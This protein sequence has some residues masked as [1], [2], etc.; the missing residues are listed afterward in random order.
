M[1]SVKIAALIEGVE[2]KEAKGDM[3]TEVNGLALDSRSIQRGE[4]FVALKGA[5]ADGRRYIPEA[6]SGGAAAVVM[7][8]DLDEALQLGVPCVVVEDGRKALAEMACNLH[9]RPS[10]SLVVIGVTGTNG[11]TTTAHIIRAILERAGNK[12]GM[13][14]TIYYQVGDVR[15]PAPY[16]TPEAPEFQGLLREMLE[17][18]C[19]HV[20]SE[21]SSHSLSQRRVDGTRFKG[22]VF[23]NLT[24]EHLDFHHDMEEY[25]SAKR[26]LFSE[27]LRGRAVINVDDSYGRRLAG[28]LPADKV[29][30][31][32][33]RE[34]AALR[35]VDIDNSGRGLTFNIAYNG[36]LYKAQ[37]QLISIVN[38]YN[39]LSAVGA[40]L[41]IGVEWGDILA[42]V[43]DVK[44]V[45]GRF[46]RVEA[47]QDFLCIVDYAHTEDALERLIRTAR[48]ITG[49]KVITLFGCGGDRDRGKRPSMG[50]VATTLSDSVI[51]TT[52]NPRSESPERIIAQIV[53]G[54]VNENYTVVVDR[55]EAIERAVAM[56]KPGDTVLIAGKGHEEY[57]EISG[58]RTRFS[59]IEI[60]REAM[61][62]A[63]GRGK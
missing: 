5:R 24:P 21:V 50:A 14:G 59:D 56:A 2:V 63:Q 22:A 30:T 43:A 62:R 34:E 33:I 51:I 57:Q 35:A 31:C 54:A 40:C 6:V 8:G 18:G 48:D 9:G 60:A 44:G 7:E 29:L 41:S 12:T 42:G 28:E 25:F 23:T 3:D 38:V 46:M 15:K 47:G 4:A 61:S 20:V 36:E 49:G 55:R 37:S 58:V 10:E 39:I 32:G 16:T 11:K 17:A 27:M 45:Q 1:K 13:I 53:E 26:R 52:D 19:T